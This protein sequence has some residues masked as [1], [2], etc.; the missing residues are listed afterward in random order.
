[1]AEPGPVTISSSRPRRS[2]SG[3]A[4]QQT[5]PSR[6]RS[7]QDDA[8]NAQP[9]KRRQVGIP[10]TE[11]LDAIDLSIDQEAQATLEA[12][13]QNLIASQKLASD[14]DDDRA[15]PIGQ[16]NCIICLDNFTDITTTACGII[17]RTL[18]W[19]GS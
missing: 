2:S 18:L 19:I 11:G 10:D 12:Q 15:I 9:P 4:A 14:T 17:R 1:M 16:K 6:K 3:L 13:T 5:A 7:R 8:P